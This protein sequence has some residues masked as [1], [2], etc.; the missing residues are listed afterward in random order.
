MDTIPQDHH[1]LRVDRC[2]KI[3]FV[4]EKVEKKGDSGLMGWILQKLHDQIQSCIP[5]DKQLNAHVQ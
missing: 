2:E 4:F 1:R 3:V 5:A